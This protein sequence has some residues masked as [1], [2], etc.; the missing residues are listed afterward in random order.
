MRKSIRPL[1]TS[2][3][4]FRKLSGRHQIS[5][6]GR[7]LI[8]GVAFGRPLLKRTERPPVIIP[9]RKRRRLTYDEDS[10][11]IFDETLNNQQDAVHAGLADPNDISIADDSGVDDDYSPDEEDI[12]ELSM[13]LKDL[14][15][16]MEK[17]HVVV[18]EDPEAP[19]NQAGA[20]TS[21]RRS[22]RSRKAGGLGLEGEGML[23]LVDET[24]RPYPREYDNPL[25]DL[26][27]YEDDETQHQRQSR[28]DHPR[29]RPNK[30]NCTSDIRQ[31]AERST[32]ASDMQPERI[33]R[34]VSDPAWK[35]VRFHDVH[36]E[37]PATVR[38]FQ[39]SDHSD[40]E[41]FL[42]SSDMIPDQD[43]SDKENSEPRYELAA[44]GAVS[45]INCPLKEVFNNELINHRSFVPINIPALYLRPLKLRARIRITPFVRL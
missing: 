8:D 31:S 21:P 17:D 20:A 10:N 22:A 3:L 13:E 23:K 25:L 41:D 4:R 37:T 35:G 38:N 27:L 30:R 24:G 7:H 45:L 2:D 15:N 26:Y 14:R 5:A 39:D 40:R 28:P 1:Q 16:D 44:S 43:G 29:V 34:D 12:D 33:N 42:P 6:D 19:L 9:P 32:E 18:S 36:L 11:G